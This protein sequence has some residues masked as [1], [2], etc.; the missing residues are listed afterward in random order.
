M[1][2]PRKRKRQQEGTR[3]AGPAA[4][5]ALIGLSVAQFVKAGH[6]DNILVGALLAIVLTAGGARLDQAILR[7]LGDRL[8]EAAG[9]EARDDSGTGDDSRDRR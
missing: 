9:D 4:A 5:I 7:N 1:T 8:Y 6:V 3:W 2:R